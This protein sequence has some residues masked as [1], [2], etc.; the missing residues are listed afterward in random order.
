MYYSEMNI[1]LLNE[2]II[3]KWICY[4]VIHSLNKNHWW[5]LNLGHQYYHLIQKLKAMLLET[6]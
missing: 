1:L 2:Y 4:S 5:S 3:L 6:N